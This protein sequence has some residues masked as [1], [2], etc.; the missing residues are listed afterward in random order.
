MNAKRLRQVVILIICMITAFC[1][2]VSAQAAE[3]YT[4]TELD[5]M[6]ITLP[7]G[8]SAIT[9][10]SSSSDKYFSV[11]G[12]DYSTTLRTFE[13]SDIYLQGM[14]N[15]ASITVTVTM[16]KTDE[17]KSIGNYV[18]LNQDELTKI[19]NNFLNLGEYNSCTP[20]NGEKLVWL[21]F[22][23][24]VS[25]GGNTI[26]TYQANTV[27]DGMSINITMQR[28]E[29][30]VTDSDYRTFS[31][32]VSSVDFLKGGFTTDIMPYIIIG[33]TIVLIIL[34]LIIIIFAGRAVKHSKRRKNNAILEELASKYN[35]SGKNDED[36][37]D[38]DKFDD[39][40]SNQSYDT[41]SV[42]KHGFVTEDSIDNQESKRSG[43]S[44][45]DEIDDII[46][47]AK[48]Y[49]N[50]LNLYS[51]DNEGYKTDSMN[52]GNK[53]EEDRQD[54]SA[55]KS[56][57]HEAISLHPED[58]S[59]YTEASESES[60]ETEDN[61]YDKPTDDFYT[62]AIF[63]SDIPEEDDFENDEELVRQQAK[64]SK[65]DS[66][67]DFFEEAPKKIMGVIKSRDIKDAE[68]YDV[69]EEVEEKVTK[70]ETEGERKPN[71]LIVFFA[72]AGRSI[73]S[74]GIH[75][76]YFCKNI[77]I[78]IKR[79]RAA[80]KRKKADEERRE[81]ARKRAEREKQR[82]SV[83]R[84]DSGLVRVHSRSERRPQQTR[85][86]QNPRPKNSNQQHRRR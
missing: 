72:G 47:S 14:D 62:E 42:L 36:V 30:N 20:D 73:K 64:R 4:V 11:F 40:N 66:G 16:T 9:R 61:T 18:Q 67:Y 49:K 17:S 83:Q 8:M 63:G 28:N 84:E 29:G 45:D 25:G 7:D 31:Q 35:L 81:R 27:Y 32:M 79:K 38:I 71:Q 80:A 12:L 19:R 33:G 85:K 15:M 13:N 54:T 51:E 82:A 77:S 3:S 24:A 43:Y 70:V 46:N 52:D 26:K 34:L 58:L 68:D 50:A 69:I 23:V 86:P 78:M 6:V 75:L 56:E 60:K 44:S 1:G 21:I 55:E 39:S 10:K 59:E 65:F 57:K 53:S 74:F 37:Y 48:E 76:G 41:G 22:D 5:D 2:I